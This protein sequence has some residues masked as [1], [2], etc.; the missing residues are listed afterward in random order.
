MCALSGML[1]RTH[2]TNESIPLVMLIDN[3]GLFTNT[4]EALENG[5]AYFVETNEVISAGTSILSLGILS[6]AEAEHYPG[7]QGRGLVW[8]GQFFDHN[9]SSEIPEDERGFTVVPA[10]SLNTIF[11][12]SYTHQFIEDVVVERIGDISIVPSGTPFELHRERDD[13]WAKIE[14]A[15]GWNMSIDNLS[16]AAIIP[17][18]LLEQSI[19]INHEN[20]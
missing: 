8:L 1:A 10:N 12:E 17:E 16:S 4:Q 9:Y 7:Y 3:S 2:I 18:E 20:Q 14:L 15:D 6:E 5:E 19:T 13:G 11:R